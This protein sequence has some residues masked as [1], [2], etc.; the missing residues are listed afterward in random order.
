M[1]PWVADHMLSHNLVVLVIICTRLHKMYT[2][3]VN[4]FPYSGTGWHGL[5]NVYG[6]EAD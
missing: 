6:F 3:L 1:L 2:V 4:L 5:Y